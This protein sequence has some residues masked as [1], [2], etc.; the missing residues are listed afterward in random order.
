MVDAVFQQDGFDVRLDWGEHGVTALAPACAVLVIVDVLSFSTATTIAV[1]NGARVLPLRWRDERAA[2]Q[3]DAAGAVLAGTNGWTLRPASL[4]EL[5]A[6]TLLGLPS[7]NG[8]TLCAHA[9]TFPDTT[10]LVGCLRNASAVAALAVAL[11]GSRPVGVIA[12]GERWGI[13]IRHEHG[14]GTALRPCV[15]DMLGAGAIVEA[16]PGSRSP[17]A[18]LAAAAFAA[19]RGR[20]AGLLHG[21]ASGQELRA[22]GHRADVDLAAM[23][24]VSAATPKLTDGVLG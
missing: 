8:A 17:E 18:E 10:V 19:S 2:Q 20:L 5:P 1:G 16:L 22:S 9:S 3:A 23:H 11:A 15:E 21:C 24:D 12:A 7:P 13:D 14:D 6:G 4:V